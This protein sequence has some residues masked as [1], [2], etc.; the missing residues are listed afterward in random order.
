[1]SR[2]E[3]AINGFRKIKKLK[4]RTLLSRAFNKK[5]LINKEIGVHVNLWKWCN[6]VGGTKK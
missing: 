2:P 6:Y 5:I 4:I 3:I 1:M